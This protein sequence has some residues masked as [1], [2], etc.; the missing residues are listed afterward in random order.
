MSISFRYKLSALRVEEII[1]KEIIFTEN[2]IEKENNV[3]ASRSTTTNI[4]GLSEW[5]SLCAATTQTRWSSFLY[6]QSRAAPR[7]AALHYCTYLAIVTTNDSRRQYYVRTYTGTV[8]ELSGHTRLT[9]YIQG[10]LTQ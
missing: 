10:E 9:D 6:N 4:H 1:E 8:K 5:C 2:Q 7:G 3:G